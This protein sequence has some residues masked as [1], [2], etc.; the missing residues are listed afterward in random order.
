ML[1]KAG[2]NNIIIE[3]KQWS[4][5]EMFWKIRT[6]KDVK[7][8]FFTMTIKEKLITFGRIFKKYGFKGV[9][10]ILRNEKFFWKTVLSGKLGYA[11][12]KGEK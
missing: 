4:K 8:W 9:F 7:H 3:Y 5:P 10:T 11:L 2:A 6:D 1:K 12:F